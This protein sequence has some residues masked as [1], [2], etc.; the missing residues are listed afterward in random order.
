MASY[1][2][3]EK[4]YKKFI[5]FFD[6]AEQKRRWNPLR[7][8][9]WSEVNRDVPEEL[10]LCAETFLG[11]ESYLPDYIRGGL[12]AIR[13]SSVA[14]RW[15]TANWGYEELKHSLALTEYLVRSGKRTEEQM[16]DFQARLMEERWAPPFPTGRQMSIYAMFQ[17]QATFVIYVRHEKL[18]QAHG[19][20]ALATVYRLNARDE[21]AHARFYE[22]VV[23]VYLDE[24]RDATVED[25]AH[26][27]RN[28]EM[29][30][31]GIVPDYDRRIEVMRGE[32][33]MDRDMFLKKVYFPLLR[34]LGVSRQELTSAARRNRQQAAAA[35]APRA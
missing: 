3:H 23:R 6:E 19:D 33:K 4:L 30:G 34:R 31:V 2:F 10:A 15:F 8:V 35:T 21:C 26:V 32:G 22:D 5:T 28:F 20:R 16:H 1:E 12:E 25:L 9:P 29:P 11:V 18:A 14:Q 13:A 27:A 17:E 7:D 24:D